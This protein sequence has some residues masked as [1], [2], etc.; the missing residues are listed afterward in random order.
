MEEETVEPVS[1]VSL[2]SAFLGTGSGGDHHDPQ[3]LESIAVRNHSTLPAHPY[4]LGVSAEYVV[5]DVA[6]DWAVVASRAS[7]HI[8]ILVA[9][10]Y[11]Y[12]VAPGMPGLAGP[13][14]PVLLPV[15]PVPQEVSKVTTLPKS[16]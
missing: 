15:N 8:P 16:P 9:T 5:I 6:I 12:V 3:V 2:Y 7:H 13:A 4:P 10:V 11:A 1:L 14:T